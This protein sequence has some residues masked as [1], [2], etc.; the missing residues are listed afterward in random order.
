MKFRFTLSRPHTSIPTVPSWDDLGNGSAAWVGNA[1]TLGSFAVS[2]WLGEPIQNPYKGTYEFLLTA[3]GTIAGAGG[4]TAQITFHLLDKDQNI[5]NSGDAIDI[6]NTG[7]SNYLVSIEATLAIPYYIMV[8]VNNLTSSSNTVTIG[9][10][11]QQPE[12][13]KVI[14]EPD[15]W[16]QAKIKWERDASIFTLIEYYLGGANNAF[17]FYGANGN[18]DGGYHF[19][20]QAENDFGYDAAVRFKVE[21]SDEYPDNFT[22]LFEGLLDLSQKTEMVDNKIQVPVIRDGP[23]SVMKNRWDTPV[24]MNATVNLD[25]NPVDPVNTIEVYLPSQ[26]VRKSFE[27]ELLHTRT[28]AENELTVGHFIQL[29]VDEY[30]LDEIDEKHTIP[31]ITNPERPIAG[32]MTA[33]EAGEYTFDIR[34]EISVVYYE[35][36]GTY[37]DCGLDRKVVG[38]KNYIDLF[39]QIDDQ[40]PIQLTEDDSP[41]ISPDISTI[42]T[43]Q[44][45]LALNEKSQIKIYAE[46]TGDIGSLGDAGQTLFI[47]SKNNV[48]LIYVPTGVIDVPLEQCTFLP[49]DSPSNVTIAAPSLEEIPTYINIMAKTVYPATSAEGYLIHDAIDGVLR[50]IGANPLYSE[51]LGHTTN[52]SRTYSE[53]GCGW[54]YAI[55]KGLQ[56][57]GY[58]LTEK[59]FFVSMKDLWEGIN[60]ILNLGLGYDIVNTDPV[61]R[62]EPKEYFF[63]DTG[64][65]TFSFVRD[66]EHNYDDAYIFK[67]V[68]TGYKQ[69][70]SEDISGLDDPQTKHTRASILRRS[71]T[72]LM[73]ES[74]FIAASLA[75]ENTRRRRKEK[76]A[77]YKFDNN[78][79]IIALNTSELS[80]NVYQPELDENFTSITNLNDPETRYNS[81]LTPMRNCLRWAN[82]WSGCLQPY[83]NSKLRFVS[84]E[85]NYDMISNFLDDGCERGVLEGAL[86]EKA[87]IPLT[88]VEIP[89]FDY[90]RRFDY[91][92]LPEAFK[93]V[94]PIEKSDFEKL[95][96]NKPI[97]ISQTDSNHVKFYIKD[98][99][100]DIMQGRATIIAWPKTPFKTQ[101]IK[102]QIENGCNT[103]GI[104]Y[105]SND[106][107]S[108]DFY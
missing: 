93:I 22:T 58:S 77:D 3:S 33:E 24:D 7:L 4:N 42:Y 35:V 73:L 49:A 106:F 13:T 10:I 76:T 102:Q 9:A 32:I 53:D 14:S 38:S 31:I 56:L 108:Q 45:T 64:V 90:K 79:F 59:P 82:Y 72:D 51:F 11:Y 104:E 91:L 36:T 98:M 50:R 75:I 26:I 92:F 8:Q 85:G 66:I 87:D 28:F 17:V 57:R 69:W 19:I 5:I 107:S 95:D 60:P 30:G 29:D 21:W 100:Y 25:G 47:H 54:M 18:V 15:G 6:P 94:I 43:Y 34:F 80:P 88:F 1:V 62:I 74:D 68:K 52:T 78:N 103:T 81:M 39:L 46:I 2:N 16:A 67:T 12:Y 41:L 99:E 23:W 65:A 83:L 105:H 61:V 44:G 101:V 89:S 96:R 40:A 86:A 63:E 70:Q 20:K 48:G 27:G 55:I 37:P 97:N 71:G 84:G